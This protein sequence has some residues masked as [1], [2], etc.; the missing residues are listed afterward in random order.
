[1]KTYFIT[2]GLFLSFHGMVVG[3]ELDY[4]RNL[5][6]IDVIAVKSVHDMKPY[7]VD[8]KRD[9]SV[10]NEGTVRM[11]NLEKEVTKAH[12]VQSSIDPAVIQNTDAHLRRDTLDILIHETDESH[13]H[14]FQIQIIGDKYAMLYDFS[15]P[16]D[17]INRFNETVYSKL[18]LNNGSLKKGA[19]VRGYVEYKGKC[20]KGC[21]NDEGLIEVKGNFVVKIR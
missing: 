10:A 9:Y 11:Y 13:N 18:Y 16:I 15:T 17:S 12:L 19:T 14:N 2:I 5:E 3:Q 1:M 20:V 7:I 8:K 21:A 6:G 4:I